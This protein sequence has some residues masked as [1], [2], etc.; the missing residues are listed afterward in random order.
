MIYLV[1]RNKTLFVS[2][3][4][5]EVS[6]EEAMKILLPL[7]LVQFDT[8]T[9]GLDAH[10]KELLT[11][12]LGCKENQVVFDWTTMSAEEKAEIKNYFESDRVFLGW[13]LMFDLGFLYVQDIWPNYIWDG[14][15]A[16]KLLWLGYPANI[17]E[18]SLKAAAWNYLN[19]DLDKSVRGKI[20]N[21]GLTEDVVVYAAGDVMWL[22]DIKEK[23]EIE[24]AKQELNLA[25]KLEC[26]FIKSLA[27]F[28]H[29]GVHLDVVKWRNK[30]AKDLVKLKD[31]EQELNDW[32][33][34][35]DSEK[36]HEHDGWDIKY[37]ELEFYNLMEIEDEVA[38]LLKEKYVR[39]PQEDLETPDGKVKAYRKRVI[40]QFTKVDNQG[41]LFNGFDTKPKCT[42]NWSS[43]QQVI[44]LFELLGIKVKT[45]DKQTKKEKKSVEA[46][47]LAPQ[48]KDFP[49]IP[50]YLKYQEAAKV[51]STYEENWLKAIN[52]K[53]GR[54]HVDFHSLGA[55]TA[56]VS[57]GGGVYKL[58]L[59]NLPH[60]KETR[61]CFTAEKGNKWISADY[62][63]Q[64]SRII[65]SVSKDEA[66][67]ELFEHGC[68]DVHSLV[69]KMS[70]PNIIPRDC[71][72]EDIAKLYHAQRQDAKG[73]E[74]AINYGGD[75]NTIANN[76]GLPLSEAQEIYDNFMKGFPGVK[77]Y[78][79]YCRIAV[80]RDGYILLNPI[81]KHRA[82]IYDIDDLWRI[83]KKVNDPEFW[84][85]YREMKRDSP[86]CDTVQDVKR[87]FQRKAASEKQSINYRIQ[88]RGAMC[89]KLS[90]IKLFNWIKEH[91]LLNI[92]K[93]CVPVHDEFNLECPESI[94][95]EVSKV[96]VKCM[97]DGG[98]PFCPNVFL[99]ADVTVSD[100]WIH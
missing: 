98:K 31:A 47:L 42:I 79:D 9:K 29:C 88:N 81:T 17:R 73:I 50:I 43:P 51:V 21:D 37:P 40:S 78:Q 11:V 58:N 97:I 41:D 48:A 62:Q 66:M 6:F 99:G 72:I 1:S 64:E 65:A 44:K 75:A 27:Y 61:A 85:Y 8:E 16:E 77:Q 49:I 83:S 20:I 19:Y 86:G 14:M 84:N 89:F 23:Q 46:K 96:L 28:K 33:V 100:H 13:N 76:K 60:D 53:T 92:V 18:M 57:S 56:R 25:M 24:L 55:D 38:R 22:E 69:A 35:W 10:T 63:S 59:Q 52:P 82:H 5:K 94:A 2:T 30:M 95:D 93:M 68:G 36:R 71:P 90:S 70:Y 80:M 32:V 3:K 15:I 7:S 34:Q 26:E 91:K 54:I 74:F 12:Q 87:Y 39:C 45:F 67:I 4:Y